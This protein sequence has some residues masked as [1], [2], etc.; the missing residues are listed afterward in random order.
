MSSAATRARP[1]V[2]FPTA[3]LLD[4]LKHLL[5]VWAV[6]LAV[7]A[8][9]VLLIDL[10][11][12]TA[13][14]EWL[15][16]GWVFATDVGL[17]Y[18]AGWSGYLTY[19]LAPLYVSHGRTRREAAAE[20]GLLLLGLALVATIAVIAGFLVEHAFLGLIG[21][22]PGIPESR[23]FASH[24]DVLGMIGVFLPAFIL[25]AA[26][27]AVVGAAVYRFPASGWAMI[28]PV[29]L[30]FVLYIL[31]SAT[32]LGIALSGIEAGPAP[33]PLRLLT[34][35]GTLAAFAGLAWLFIRNTPVRTT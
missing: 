13:L 33:F 11:R 2:R 28:L 14:R 23:G 29:L 24:F 18:I 25:A 19:W 22:E 4:N 12:L 1:E 3:P 10:L 20:G 34:F 9:A 27:A 6:G 32:S 26:G 8:L 35:V 17:W 21:W 16:S 5:I 7:V 15:Q 30:L 31:I